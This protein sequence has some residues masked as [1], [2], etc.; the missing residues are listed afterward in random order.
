MPRAADIT[1]YE[2][3]GVTPDASQE[4]I[5]EAFRALARLLHPDQQTDQQLKEI[6]ELQMRKINRIYGVLSDPERRRRYDVFLQQ[7]D[8]PRTVVLTPAGIPRCEAG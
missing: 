5:R 8:R 7:E 4:Q 6:A 1:Y 3:L 2:E